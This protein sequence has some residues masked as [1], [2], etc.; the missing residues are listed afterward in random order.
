MS[1]LNIKRFLD[2]DNRPEATII[3]AS[4]VDVTSGDSLIEVSGQLGSIVS[5]RPGFFVGFT[6]VEIALNETHGFI[7]GETLCIS[8][9]NAQIETIMKPTLSVHIINQH[10]DL[11][12]QDLEIDSEAELSL[13]LKTLARTYRGDYDS[14]DLYKGNGSDVVAVRVF[15]KKSKNGGT[16]ERAL[17]FSFSII[18]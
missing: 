6:G 5:S 14:S 15:F 13:E 2:S 1:E 11:Y 4:S 17:P 8:V 18:F 10:G 12:G 9:K 16:S 3:N 7:K